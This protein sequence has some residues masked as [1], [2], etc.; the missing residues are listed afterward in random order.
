M[1]NPY[2][3]LLAPHMLMAPKHHFVMRDDVLHRMLP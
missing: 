1:S 2:I 3:A